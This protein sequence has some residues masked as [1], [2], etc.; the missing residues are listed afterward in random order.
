MRRAKASILGICILVTGCGNVSSADSAAPP[1][2]T[3][4]PRPLV[5]REL[6]EL[7]LA[8]EQVAATMGAPA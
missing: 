7:L 5:E 6:G 3:M 1:S 8:P 4:I 2:R